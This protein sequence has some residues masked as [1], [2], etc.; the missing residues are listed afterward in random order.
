MHAC[1]GRVHLKSSHFS[2]I[3][4]SGEDVQI[5]DPVKFH[6]GKPQ[7]VLAFQVIFICCLLHFC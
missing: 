1:F 5:R 3:E 6:R 4:S 2:H 7:H